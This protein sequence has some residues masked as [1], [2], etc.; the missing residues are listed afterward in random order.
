[1]GEVVIGAEVEEQRARA[2]RAAREASEPTRKEIHEFLTEFFKD[3]KV[4]IP[5]FGNA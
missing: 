3:S 2:E 5:P 4:V 1:M